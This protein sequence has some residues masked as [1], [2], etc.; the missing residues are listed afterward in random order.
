MKNLLFGLLFLA[1]CNPAFAK[2]TY[3]APDPDIKSYLVSSRVFTP[4]ATP[5]DMCELYGSATK[6]IKV[7]SVEI[8]TSQGTSGANTFLFIKRST[9]NTSALGASTSGVIVP[10]DTSSPASTASMKSYT[11]NPNAL[12]TALG[13]LLVRRELTAVSS[14]LGIPNF[15]VNFEAETGQPLILRGAAEGLV[16]NFQG[17]A[18]PATMTMQCTYKFVEE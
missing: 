12:G 18:L 13:T 1:S 10:L 3:V 11:T 4:P 6:V 9:V 15:S 14:A 5:T 16:V 2:P 8:S 7:K 17:Y